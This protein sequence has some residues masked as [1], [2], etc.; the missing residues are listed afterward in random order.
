[1]TARKSR[2]K[3]HVP[4]V[5]SS[6]QEKA[7]ASAAHGYIPS[8]AAIR[9]T[10]ESVVIAF[11]LAFLFR[12]F[13]TEAFVI[14]T[15]S[16]APTLMGR[17][18]DM[19]CPQCG[20]PYQLSASS[21]VSDGAPIH[22]TAG[23]CP[24]CRYTDTNLSKDPSYNGD[25]ILVGKLI[26]QFRE[27]QRW[28]VIVFKFPGDGQTDSQTNFIKRLIG[29]PGETVRI[30]NGDIWIRR[31]DEAGNDFHIERKPEDKLLAILQPVFD[32]RYMPPIANL[33]WP[34]RWRP[35]ATQGDWNCNDYVTF[36]T[37]GTA[38]DENWLRYEHRVPSFRQWQNF[39]ATG[40]V[41]A[42][43]VEPR[44]ITDFMAYNTGRYPR[45]L[46]PF[47]PQ[48]PPDSL[49]R[50]WVG[51]LA[52]CCTVDV[53]GETGELVFELRKGGRRFQCRI[54]VSTGRATLSVSGDDMMQF[55]PTATTAVRGP[56]R[57][58]IRFSNCDNQMLLW[59]DGRLV[60]FDSTTAYDEHLGNTRPD[61]DDKRPV[62]VA[63]VGVPVE[64]SGLRVLRDIFYI[65]IEGTPSNH[66]DVLY[67]LGRDGH[68]RVR[69]PFG[70]QPYVEFSL[71]TDQFFVLG[72]NSAYSKDGRL[73]GTG[74]NFVPR[75]LLIGKALLIY[76]PHSWDRIPY[77]NIPFPFF[78]NFK[79]MGLVR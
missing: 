34:E 35:D 65:A 20:C 68:F 3:S 58:D 29:L 22:V 53:R 64:I 13:E 59:V 32:N 21:E 2:G 60:S 30:Q 48:P 56:G 78:P 51:D 6:R 12:T 47:Y 62:G 28:D 33:G 71:E 31:G 27:P 10:I 7:P 66:H 38:A 75:E 73:W 17:H 24:M 54:D 50:H 42:E 5:P 19:E 76:W 79:D 1:M 63:S 49:G 57:H 15:G 8:P 41:V 45:D 39:F 61:D 14:P 72:D 44:W 55:R 4:A 16:M 46:F 77:V 25:R 70:L 36:Q 11:I 52:L 69:E 74:N 9:E 67:Q 43:E 23:T 37:D 18:K 40:E 26:Y